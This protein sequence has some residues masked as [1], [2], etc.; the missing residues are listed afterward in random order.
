[1]SF[2]SYAIHV[3]PD[4]SLHLDDPHPLVFSG[5]NGLIAK[6]VRA[7]PERASEPWI[8][9]PAELHALASPELVVVRRMIVFEQTEENK[10]ERLMLESVRGISTDQTEMMFT[11]RPLVAVA[12]GASGPGWKVNA[13]KAYTEGLELEGGVSAPRASWRWGRPHLALGGVVCGG[14]GKAKP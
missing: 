10:V 9:V 7:T 3:Q 4:G 6:F 2:K 1:M 5:R 8:L 12:G 13:G 11:F 14:G